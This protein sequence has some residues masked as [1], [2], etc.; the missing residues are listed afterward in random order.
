MAFHQV[1]ASE[2]LLDRVFTRLDP[3]QSLRAQ[4][5]LTICSIALVTA[6]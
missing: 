4:L 5:G 2:K 3:R 1:L 6:R